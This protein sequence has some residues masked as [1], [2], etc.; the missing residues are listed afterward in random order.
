[1]TINGTSRAKRSVVCVANEDVN[2]KNQAKAS[3]DTAAAG[4]EGVNKKDGKNLDKGKAVRDVALYAFLR[5]LLFLVLTFIIH[6]IVILLGMADYFP[7]LVSMTLAL[8]LALPLSMFMFK[9]LRLRVTEQIARWDAERQA[10]RQELRDQL[11][12]RLDD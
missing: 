9:G 7:L 2:A 6:S 5:L 3:A 11:R 8:I 4:D 1:M 10:H 12:E